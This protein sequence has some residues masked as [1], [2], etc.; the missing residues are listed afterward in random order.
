MGKLEESRFA[1][2]FVVL[3]AVAVTGSCGWLLFV[4]APTL[5]VPQSDRTI[6]ASD[7]T[8]SETSELPGPLD[9]PAAEVRGRAAVVVLG[10]TFTSGAAK[11]APDATWPERVCATAGCD[12]D[13][14]Y[15]E[16][17]SG[18]VARG[19]EGTRFG[20]RVDAVIAAKP[21]VVV[22]AGG[23]FDKG[24]SEQLLQRRVS[25][26]L[27]RLK[28]GLPKSRI[29][30]LSPFWRTTPIPPEIRT[31]REVV[32]SQAVA[33]GLDFVDVAEIFDAPGNELVND[34]GL[35]TPEGQAKIAA[36]V[37][38]AVHDNVQAA[39]GYPGG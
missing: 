23:A 5:T 18:F 24:A 30:V 14:T 38:Q 15:A 11:D 20:E 39:E 36:T 4:W 10:D 25:D 28:T 27:D 12:Y 3:F 6:G 8:S 21:D 1:T 35:P 13:P 34:D 26:V 2:V 19:V 22:V 17:G 37:G 33:N 9:S 7:L 16:A 31:M 29:L 32:R